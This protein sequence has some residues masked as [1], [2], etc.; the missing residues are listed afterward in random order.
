MADNN[1]ATATTASWPLG[2]ILT[3]IFVVLK[4]THVI[5]WHWYW[6]LAPLWISAAF[7]IFIL[8]LV[9]TIF[10]VVL[11]AKNNKKRNVR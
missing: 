11:V 9:A 3:I 2:T 1:T 4:L 8:L 10:A 7:T 5:A 6:V